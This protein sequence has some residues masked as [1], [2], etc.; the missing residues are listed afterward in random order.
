[1]PRVQPADLALVD[2]EADNRETD[3][4][5]AQCQ[6]HADIAQTQNADPG[7]AALK[8]LEQEGQAA[9]LLFGRVLF[10]LFLFSR[11]L[12]EHRHELTSTGWAGK[13]EVRVSRAVTHATAIRVKPGRSHTGSPPRR[14]DAA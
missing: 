3:G 7:S 9:A 12:Q 8:S 2:I 13:Q 4:R 1:L 11:A 5:A 14:T 10:S 6:G